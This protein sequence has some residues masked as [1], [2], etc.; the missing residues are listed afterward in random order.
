[1]AAPW[2]WANWAPPSGRRRSPSKAAT[3]R[4]DPLGCPCA[5]TPADVPAGRQRAG[6]STSRSF[7]PSSTS[8]GTSWVSNGRDGRAPTPANWR[9][10]SRRSRRRAAR[11][12][13]TR[14]SRHLAD[15]GGPVRTD[16]TRDDHLIPSTCLS[17]P[18]APASICPSAALRADLRF[19]SRPTSTAGN[20]TPGTRRVRRDE[21]LPRNDRRRRGST[22]QRPRSTTRRRTPLAADRAPTRDGRAAVDADQ[23]EAYGIDYV[24]LVQPGPR[25]T[26]RGRLRRAPGDPRPARH[27]P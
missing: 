27:G 8:P 6:Q 5:A 10:P 15:P 17:T 11:P 20:R 9:R 26:T 1:M 19:G 4:S 21:S 7:R 12:D 22:T 14:R 23:F 2:S 18:T 3:S 13:P 16:G 24:N 25:E